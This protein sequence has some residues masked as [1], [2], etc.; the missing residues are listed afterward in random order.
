MEQK[1]IFPSELAETN[2]DLY[3]NKLV[4]IKAEGKN[5]Q[6]FNSSIREIAISGVPIPTSPNDGKD[7]KIM[8]LLILYK[9]FF[10]RRFIQQP[11]N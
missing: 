9:S 8:R 3:Q 1:L 4:E 5:D 2:F 6:A 10:N 11:W 7:L